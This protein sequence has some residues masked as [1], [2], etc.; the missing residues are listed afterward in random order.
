MYT[1]LLKPTNNCNLRCNYCFIDGDSKSSSPVMSIPIAEMCFSQIHEFVKSQNQNICNILWHGGE[2]MLWGLDK[3]KHI[4]LLLDN[5][6][7]DIKFQHSIQT[8]LLLLDKD[9]I[10]FFLHYK[11]HVSTSLDGT[12]LIHDSN[13]LYKDGN[14][15]FENVLANIKLANRYGMRIG[16]ITVV[17]S[18]NVDHLPEIYEF[19]KREGIGFKL[20]PLLMIGEAVKNNSLAITV[21]A[22]A[23]A[24]KELFDIWIKEKSTI[25]I[26]NFIEIA[27][28]LAT[29]FTSV[30][31]F[32]QNCQRSFTTI[33]PNGDITPCD[34]LCG[35]ASYIFGNVMTDNLS[36]CVE[37]KKILF[38]ERYL[39]LEK[40]E[41]S[42]CSFFDICRGG[43]PADAIQYRSIANKTPF[44]EANR[45]IFEHIKSYLINNKKL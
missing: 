40:T 11:I 36:D 17:S 1:F 37:Q 18:R 6:Y 10:D 35:N 13:R 3:F 7:P 16:V 45:E 42:G 26:T 41:C 29:G 5:T 24:I 25:P 12:K 28:N 19:F 14:G 34:R 43:C 32:S 30:C 8:N 9:W 38:E 2:P 20:N 4:F 27:S 23:E 33:E 31:V 15:S 44:C 22:Y 39:E 21:K